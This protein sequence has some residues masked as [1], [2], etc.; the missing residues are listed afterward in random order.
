MKIRAYRTTRPFEGGL[1]PVTDKTRNNQPQ[2][3][4]GPH[5]KPRKDF[6]SNMG[7]DHKFIGPDPDGLNYAVGGPFWGEW[8]K[9]GTDVPYSVEVIVMDAHGKEH[10]YDDMAIDDVMKEWN[11]KSY[12]SISRRVK[13]KV[14]AAFGDSSSGIAHVVANVMPGCFKIESESPRY[15][16]KEVG[17]CFAV[18]DGE[19]VTCAH[20]ISKNSESP[21]DVSVF[22]IEGEKRHRAIVVDVDYDM[23]LAIVE[24]DTVRHFPLHL[25]S[26]EKVPVGEEIMC[27]G[28]PFG[29][30]NNVSRG[31]LSS[32]GRLVDAAGEISYF[33]IDLSVYPGNSGGPVID[34]LDGTVIGVAAIIVDSV[35]NY[36]IN[37]AIP[38]DYVARR[39][40]KNVKLNT[41]I[42]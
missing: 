27:V 31:I 35:G 4:G 10:V 32:K 16:K 41:R 14:Q 37:A 33:F 26:I 12:K 3:G 7:G 20:A 17:S 2:M 6:D 36:G 25:K 30:D 24:C 5:E 34:I 22:I 40:P 1:S 42:R 11:D 23:D 21:S 39:F 13:N 15:G 29:Y 28:S 8:S 9:S 38:S 18:T 19:F